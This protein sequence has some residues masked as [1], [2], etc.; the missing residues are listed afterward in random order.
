MLI[1]LTYDLRSAYLA[2]GYGEEETAEFDRPDT[3]EAI[4]AALI[5]L[6]HRTDRIGH[7]RQLMARLTAGDRWDLVFN[8]AE[9]LHGIGREAQVPAILDAYQIPYTFSDPLVMALCLHKGLTKMVVRAA[10]IPTADFAIV[11]RPDDLERVQ[12]PYPLFAK[13]I[14]E[15]TGKGITSASKIVDRQA[16]RQVGRDLLERFRQPVL[17]ETYL[18]GREMTVGLVGTG[19]EARVLGTLEI[20][21]N[22]DAEP[23]A[24]SYANK[25]RSEELV[26]YTLMLP[27]ADDEIRRAEDVALAAWRALNCRDAGRVDLRSDARG[28]PNFIEVNP[29]AGLHPWHSDL[30]TLCTQLGMP[31]VELVDRIVRSAAT[32]VA[33]RSPCE[34]S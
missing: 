21:L 6:G 9:G 33:A 30:P 17:I 16:L 10:G 22:P 27:D 31:Y 29:L 2:E 3:I 4:E 19:D 20:T 13:P 1:G 14:A 34:S 18:P 5:Q 8:I 28:Q 26:K 23:D 25:E 32:R 15:G 12:L 7:C 11:E 24:Y